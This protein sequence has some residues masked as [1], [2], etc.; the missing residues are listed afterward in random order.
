M[1][2]G[3]PI[4]NTNDNV[5]SVLTLNP[6]EF[7][8]AHCKVVSLIQISKFNEAIQ[9]IE[10]AKLNQ[11]VF[12]RA[13]IQYRLNQPE[14]ALKTI[15]NSDLKPLPDNLKE[16]RA[17]VLYRLEM[18]DECFDAYKNIIKNSS[19][20]YEDERATNLSAVA[21]NL[22]IEGSVIRRRNCNLFLTNCTNK[23]LITDERLLQ[24]KRR[25][26]RTRLQQCLCFGRKKQIQ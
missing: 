8:A 25:Y 12:E 3:S 21:A 15:D 14:K 1:S 18:F 11:L 10:R 19:D 2:F 23:F 24:P 9:F 6:D 7:Q 5:F 16:L 26:V 13:Y 17:Q 20:D 22:A 4:N